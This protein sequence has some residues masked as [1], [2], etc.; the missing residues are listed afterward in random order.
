MTGIPHHTVRY[1]E[2]HCLSDASLVAWS[3]L[4]EKLSFAQL[5]KKFSSSDII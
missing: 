5:I 2:A 3:C 1:E 4:L